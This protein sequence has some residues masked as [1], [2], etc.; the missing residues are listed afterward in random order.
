MRSLHFLSSL[1]LVLL[2]CLGAASM[3]AVEPTTSIPASA[4]DA[5]PITIGTP[6]PL[7]VAVKLPDGSPTTLGTVI[8][9]APTVVIFYRGGWCPFC[10]RHLAG[11]GAIVKDLSAAGWKI[12]ALAPD[13]PSVLKGVVDAGDGGVP[14]LSDA[15]GNAM[16]AFG[17]AYHV[18]DATAEHMKE[19]KIDLT[20]RSGNDH[21]WLPVPSV[22]MI[23]ADGIIRFVH[24]NP[25]YK[26]RLDPQAILNIAKTTPH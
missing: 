25:D 21:R 11:L 23:S 5:R 19:Y 16:R 1:S 26:V 13:Q 3:N 14:R 9:G 15:D 6:A 8:A 4:S 2:A 10:T 7:S 18:D 24:A 22:F 12:L 20:A 17:V